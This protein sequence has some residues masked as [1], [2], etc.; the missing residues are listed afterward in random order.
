MSA[1]LR[2]AWG[3]LVRRGSSE[4]HDEWYALKAAYPGPM[5][6]W[7]FEIVDSVPR[8]RGALG[9]ADFNAKVVYVAQWA[10]GQG[11][12]TLR[13]EVAHVLAG[14]SYGHGE[15]WKSFCREVGANPE[16]RTEL[17]EGTDPGFKWLGMCPTHGQVAGWFRRPS[18]SW[19]C[20][21]CRQDV[22]LVAA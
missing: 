22:E 12:D 9:M 18:K 2:E 19:L 5:Y 3:R 1:H 20:G 6:E 13:H 8:N 14:R 16:A 17:A 4:L 15:L 11:L 21:K 7:R 10:V